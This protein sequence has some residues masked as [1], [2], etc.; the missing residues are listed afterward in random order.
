M[1]IRFYR[2]NGGVKDVDVNTDFF[3][4]N[5][6]CIQIFTKNPDKKRMVSFDKQYCWMFPKPKFEKL[7][8]EGYVIKNESMK[9][10][11]WLTYYKFTSKANDFE[12]E[13]K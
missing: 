3:L 6:A 12:G 4:D 9:A 5:G 1:K 8:K 7:L 2:G 13:F 11:A 10:E